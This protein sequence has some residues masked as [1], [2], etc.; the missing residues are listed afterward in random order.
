MQVVK[1]EV[2]LWLARLTL[3][4]EGLKLL[5]LG[6][7][8]TIQLGEWLLLLLLL[9]ISSWLLPKMLWSWLLRMCFKVRLLY[10][11][12]VLLLSE[13][14]LLLR[15]GLLTNKRNIRLFLLLLSVREGGRLLLSSIFLPV[16]IENV[17]ELSDL[18]FR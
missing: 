9:D 8:Q 15:V 11:L 3:L 14:G 16:P 1:V 18:K 17:I 13:R 5:K 10:L 6:G 2:G 12:I 4:L 7:G